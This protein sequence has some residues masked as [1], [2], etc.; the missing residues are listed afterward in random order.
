MTGGGVGFSAS[1]II[2]GSL[3]CF[4]YIILSSLQRF[5]YHIELASVLLLLLGRMHFEYLTVLAVVIAPP[6]DAQ[7]RG[8]EISAGN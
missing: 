3:Q 1:C 8:S 2:S 6:I 4:I 5:M 7:A